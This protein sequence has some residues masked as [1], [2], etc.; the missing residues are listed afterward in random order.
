MS[1]IFVQVWRSVRVRWIM[2]CFQEKPSVTCLDDLTAHIHI[3][4]SSR[5]AMI[6][7]LTGEWQAMIA[8][9]TGEWQAMIASLTGEWQAMIASLIG[10]WQA[11]IA[12]LT[13]EWQAMIASLTGKWQVTIVSLTGEWQVIVI[14]TGTIITTTN[15][16]ASKYP[17]GNPQYPHELL[18][19]K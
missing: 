13:G 10:E 3:K 17:T 9:L 5:Q 8:S 4:A 12:Y 11:M 6:A 16:W 1:V 7:S 15:K 18:S 14:P 2:I 19:L